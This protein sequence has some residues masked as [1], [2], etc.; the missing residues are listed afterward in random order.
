MQVG[1][2]FDNMGVTYEW[3]WSNSTEMLEENGVS[4]MQYGPEMSV[5]KY[6]EK[7]HNKKRYFM[8]LKIIIKVFYYVL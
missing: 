6:L 4:R 2:D 3:P 8:P 7:N 5:V 1:W